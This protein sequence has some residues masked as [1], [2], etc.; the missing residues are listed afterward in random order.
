MSSLIHVV[1][2]DLDP[3]L[4]D[5]VKAWKVI[6]HLRQ[7]LRTLDPSKLALH[8]EPEQSGNGSA[9]G[10]VL[11]TRLTGKPQYLGLC[12]LLYL[13]AHP[14]LIPSSWNGIWVFGWNTILEGPFGR[15]FVPYLRWRDGAWRV[16][17]YFLGR[18]W[19]AS[20][21]AGTLAST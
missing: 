10:H 7:G 2:T 20:H 8:R 5:D 3:K 19:Y 9:G 11:R 1:D 16:Y 12:E 6:E 14:E 18:D 13:Q 17:F 15:L 4:P 21:P